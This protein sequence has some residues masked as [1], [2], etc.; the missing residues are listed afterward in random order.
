MKLDD[1]LLIE[2]SLN[3]DLYTV[4][5]SKHQ[6]NLE[7]PRRTLSRYIGGFTTGIKFMSV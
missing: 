4:P 3:S 7:I 1:P 6:S 2:S 5:L